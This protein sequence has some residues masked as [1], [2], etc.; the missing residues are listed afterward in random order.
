M[1]VG[2]PH[3][4]LDIKIADLFLAEIVALAMHGEGSHTRVLGEEHGVTVA[5]VHIAVDDENP[6]HVGVIAQDH[7]RRNSNIGEH[8]KAFPIIT[9]CMVCTSCYMCCNK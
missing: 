2:A 9:K 1:L 8:T 6:L 7:I 3:R 5:L 4:K